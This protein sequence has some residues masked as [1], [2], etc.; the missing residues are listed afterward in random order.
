[1]SPEHRCA[2][3]GCNNPVPT[4]P[5]R[6]GRPPIY[7]SANCRPSR[8]PRTV[9]VEVDRQD[10]D[11]VEA[12]REWTVQLRRGTQTVVVGHDLGRFSAT[13]LA[14]DLRRVLGDDRS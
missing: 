4:T 12:G 2:R 14:T 1:M 8:L 6:R 9:A 3:D 10:G 5:G 7:C 13:A 11:D